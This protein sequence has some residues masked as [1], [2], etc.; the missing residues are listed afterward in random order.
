MTW[1]AQNFRK[2]NIFTAFYQ[3]IMLF[4]K[5]FFLQKTMKI[6]GLKHAF[7]IVSDKKKTSKKIFSCKRG[8]LFFFKGALF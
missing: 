3:K 7:Q 8:R 1:G 6:F 5:Q 2:S 4:I